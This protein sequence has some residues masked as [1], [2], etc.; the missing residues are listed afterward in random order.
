MNIY[1]HSFSA[2]CVNNGLSIAYHVEIRTTW[3]IMVEDIAD[4]CAKARDAEKP[5]HETIADRLYARFG[6]E[7]IMTAFHHGVGIET[8]RGG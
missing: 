1:R 8:R 3:T 5:Y 4:E 7:Q 2:P 6:G